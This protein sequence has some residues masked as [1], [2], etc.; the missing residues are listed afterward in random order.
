M[1]CD[2]AMRLAVVIHSPQI[3]AIRHGREGA[4]ERQDFQAVTGKIEVANDFGAQQRDHV[5][6][7]RELES[8][9]NFFS[10]GGTS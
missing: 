3:I 2:L 10:Y 9:E 8:R 6:A 4:I 7:D 1:A 5:R